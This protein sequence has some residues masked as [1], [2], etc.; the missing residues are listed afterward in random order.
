ML[1]VGKNVLYL[2]KSD[3]TCSTAV[4]V[5]YFSIEMIIL[6]LVGCGGI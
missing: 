1:T 2:E 6:K 4:N 3:F 5:G